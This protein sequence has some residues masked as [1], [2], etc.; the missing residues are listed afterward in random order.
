TALSVAAVPLLPGAFGSCF[1]V[2]S[3]SAALAPPV[4]PGVYCYRADGLLTAAK[5]SF[6]TLTLSGT[7]GAA[8]PPVTMPPPLAHRTPL[9]PAR[10]APEPVGLTSGGVICGHP[11][12]ARRPP[13]RPRR[14]R[15]RR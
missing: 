1:S 6:G 4:D 15:S 9:R 14:R 10:H 13:R 12:R 7:V 5:V 3:N 11:T 8:P 2:E